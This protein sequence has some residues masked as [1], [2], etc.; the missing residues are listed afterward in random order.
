MAPGTA[1]RDAFRKW[2]GLSEQRPGPEG[3]REPCIGTGPDRIRRQ[4]VEN[5]KPLDT[6]W[7]VKSHAIGDATAT[8]MSRDREARKSKPLHDG[9]H[10]LRHGPLRIWC[11]V[12]RG[13]GT[14][15]ASVAAKIGADDREVASKQRRDAAPH[16]V[17]LWKAVQQEDRWPGTGR[18]HEDTGFTRLDLGGGEVIHHFPFQPS[19]EF[20]RSIMRP[21]MPPTRTDG[22]SP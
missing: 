7:M 5:G 4:D 12:R 6:I 10:V 21:P 11:M 18:A 15:A 16:Q 14:T 17:C 3:E 1:A 13:D 9:H 19:A 2:F 20:P 22:G 8:I